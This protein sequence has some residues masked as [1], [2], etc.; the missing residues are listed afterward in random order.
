MKNNINSCFTRR[1]FGPLPYLIYTYDIGLRELTSS[2]IFPHDTGI[3]VFI[4]IEQT[5]DQSDNKVRISSVH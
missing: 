3:L 5:A 4:M 1:F 2:S